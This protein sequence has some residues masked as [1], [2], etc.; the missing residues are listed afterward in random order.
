MSII[1][2]A[3]KKTEQHIQ[4]NEARN[5]PEGEGL[6]SS[7]QMPAK[8]IPTPSP[9]LIYILILLTGIL[10]SKFIFSLLNRQEGR[11]LVSA[12]QSHKPQGDG[13]ASS[14][15]SHKPQGDGLASSSQSHKVET[16]NPTPP[17]TLST[18]I[19]ENNKTPKLNFLLNGIFFSDRDGYALVNNQIV[20]ENDV[21][22]GA[23][24]TK[25]TTNTVEL[26]SDGK[27]ISLSTGR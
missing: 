7:G 16:S 12:S 13:L 15:Q 17:L 18:V 26:D 9:W 24:V 10:L 6:A 25:I 8:I 3:L 20:R 2:E 5:S 1:N 27:L 22:D 19:P 21:V 14:S 11:S 4:K 23:K